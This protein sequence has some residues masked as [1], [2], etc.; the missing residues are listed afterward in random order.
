MRLKQCTRTASSA[1]KGAA[2]CLGVGSSVGDRV[3]LPRRPGCHDLL[4]CEA[5]VAAHDQRPATTLPT[6]H[7]RDKEWSQLQLAVD[8]K[9]VFK[10]QA[11]LRA[12]MVWSCNSNVLQVTS[13]RQCASGSDRSIAL[14]RV[15]VWLVITDKVPQCSVL[16][17]SGVCFV[18][19]FGA[20]SPT[21]GRTA[22]RCATSSTPL[23]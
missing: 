22:R 11:P 23:V 13:R 17:S 16:S 21:L 1:S 20:S 14:C 8:V 19:Q 3:E 7:A 18:A 6:T 5:R 15:T 2:S 4:R 9:S 12:W 10:A